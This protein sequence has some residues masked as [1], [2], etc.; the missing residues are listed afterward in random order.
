VRAGL[1]STAA[2]LWAL[3]ASEQAEHFSP[4]K[5]TSW[6]CNDQPHDFAGRSAVYASHRNG[7]ELFMLDGLSCDAMVP[8]A[9]LVRNGI[10]AASKIFFS[11]SRML[12][13]SF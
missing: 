11:C 13:L 8:A 12:S 2:F 1:L 5:L 6:A 3:I 7:P 10:N 4:H 9:F